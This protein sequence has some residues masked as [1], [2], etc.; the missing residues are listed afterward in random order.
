ME[1]FGTLL[2]IGGVALA[3]WT[4]SMALFAWRKARRTKISLQNVRDFMSRRYEANGRR[5]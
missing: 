3:T 4:G 1:V 5:I 2:A